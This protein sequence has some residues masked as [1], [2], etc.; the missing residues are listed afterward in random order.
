[1]VDVPGMSAD[2]ISIQ[3]SE[4]VLTIAGHKKR[5]TEERD[6]A[7]RTIRRERHF[8]SFNRSFTLPADV[9][10]DDIGA[11][12]ADGVLSVTVPKVAPPPKPEPRRIKVNMAANGGGAAAAEAVP[13]VT[14][15]RHR[16]HK[17]GGEGGAAAEQGGEEAMMAEEEKPAQ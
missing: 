17:E 3:L 8:E 2:D 10:E 7:G 13:K 12:L 16:H 4:G 5:E 1:M 14:H 9:K 6:Q 15:H 11:S